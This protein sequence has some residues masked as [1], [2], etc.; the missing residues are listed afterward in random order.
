MS[1]VPPP[2]SEAPPT[3]RLVYL[4]LAGARE[5]ELTIAELTERTGSCTRSVKGALGD[6]RQEGLVARRPHPTDGRK[7]QYTTT[8]SPTRNTSQ[9]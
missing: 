6:L 4:V 5:E 7:V 1:A 9:E 8:V 2:L 3:A